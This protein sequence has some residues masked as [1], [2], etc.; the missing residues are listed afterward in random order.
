MQTLATYIEAADEA[1]RIADE[2]DAVLGEIAAIKEQLERAKVQAATGG[3]YADPSWF[4]RAQS[5]LRFKQRRHQQLLRELG[6]AR[7]AERAA[8]QIE[9]EQA[10]IGVARE[11]LSPALYEQIVS[12]AHAASRAA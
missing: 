1:D 9:Y 4:S 12:E 8:K 2:A 5:A 6:K 11:R 10:F 7:K 3:G